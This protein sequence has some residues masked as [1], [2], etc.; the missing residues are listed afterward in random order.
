MY[1]KVVEARRRLQGLRAP[2]V[3]PPAPVVHAAGGFFGGSG[4]GFMGDLTSGNLAA[5]GKDITHAN[6]PGSQGDGSQP[7]PI[8]PAGTQVGGAAAGNILTNP[9]KGLTPQ[10]TFQATTPGIQTSDWLPSMNLGLDAFKNSQGILGN[11]IGSVNGY[12]GQQA[13][14][15][16]NVASAAGSLG[17]VL[18]RQQGLED[19]LTGQANGTGPNPAQSQFQQNVNQN[20][21]QEA[22]SIGSVKGLNPA[23][24][25]KMAAENAGQQGQAA[26]GQAATLQAQ[27]QIAA[28]QA[29]GAQQAA[30]GQTI[31][32]QGSLYGAAGS[33]Y[34]GAGQTAATGGALANDMGTQGANIFS[35]GANAQGNQNNAVNTGSLGSQG[36]DAGV[37][38]G[39]ANRT[40]ITQAGLLNGAGGAVGGLLSSMAGGG[41]VSD[42]SG[43]VLGAILAQAN[44]SI[45]IN[46]Y[47]GGKDSGGGLKGLGSTL[48]GMLGSSLFGGA[49]AWGGAAGA[50]SMTGFLPQAGE[51]ILPAAGAAGAGDA[52]AGAGVESILPEVAMVA[53]GGGR[54]AAPGH[55]KAK[56]RTIDVPEGVDAKALS[57]AS[58]L[59]A[60]GGQVPGTPNVKGNAY[61]NDVVPAALSP[62]EIVLPLSVTQAADAPAK[63]AA[64]VEKLKSKSE[65]T[66]AAVLK[67][68]RKLEEAQ[69]A[70]HKACGGMAS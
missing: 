15:A 32:N 33:L 23:L 67:A 24:A 17:G 21:A 66:Y 51:N 41:E 1:Q 58:A 40:A 39:N 36:L 5:V 54:V 69:K 16:G 26:A 29:L 6:K 62:Q 3:M 68:R 49:G 14:Q 30:E 4:G 46:D 18:A 19:M 44:P 61:K 43:S 42:Q 47:N 34:G 64:F 63:A 50:D 38:A 48:G 20:I 9:A 45:N 35:T 28:E 56:G 53:A 60:R 57:L 11:Q 70:H 52:A 37:A 13:G 55:V 22:G 10:D 27:Q 25:A 59:M 8:G 31:G 7:M 12:A 2:L 65:P